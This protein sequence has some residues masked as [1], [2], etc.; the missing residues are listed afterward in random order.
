VPDSQ[1]LNHAD[2]ATPSLGLEQFERACEGAA[3]DRALDV[4]GDTLAQASV[5]GDQPKPPS[6][7]CKRRRPFRDPVV[8]DPAAGAD[9][10]DP[11]VQ[12]GLAPD[13][14]GARPSKTTRARTRSRSA[15]VRRRSRNQSSSRFGQ[16]E[17]ITFRASTMIT[18]SAG[19]CIG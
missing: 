10:R 8:R 18:G 12:L 11:F 6:L 4:R 19:A 2:D 3:A 9:D 16:R 5:G 1:P 17:R 14:P 7:G 13:P 15:Q